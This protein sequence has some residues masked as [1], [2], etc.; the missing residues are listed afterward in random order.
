MAERSWT[1]SWPSWAGRW[2]GVV[3]RVLVG[4]IGTLVGLGLTWL[5]G[6]AAT[7]K[8]NQPD[9]DGESL[10]LLVLGIVTAVLAIA[11]ALRPSRLTVALA[12]ATAVAIPTVGA[13]I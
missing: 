4:L 10:T 13:N 9:W 11:L 1:R 3:F 6:F 2:Y 12:A 8:D 7:F 5:A